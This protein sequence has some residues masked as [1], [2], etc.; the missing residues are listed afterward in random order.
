MKVWR[1]ISK[2]YCAE[3]LQFTRL[4]DLRHECHA[5]S[6][7]RTQSVWRIEKDTELRDSVKV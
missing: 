1:G 7:E 3:S 4:S 2:S 6:K 5:E